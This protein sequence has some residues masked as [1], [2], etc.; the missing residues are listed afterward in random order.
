VAL[1]ATPPE[2]PSVIVGW[3][4]GEPPKHIDYVYTRAE[5]RQAGVAKRLIQH[6]GFDLGMLETG[7]RTT[8]VGTAIARIHNVRLRP[9]F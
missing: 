6:A 2:T 5:Y 7:T 3:L 4:V 9:V 8:P 1:V